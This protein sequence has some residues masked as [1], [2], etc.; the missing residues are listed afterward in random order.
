[1][2]IIPTKVFLYSSI[3]PSVNE[4][5]IKTILFLKFF[6]GKREILLEDLSLNPKELVWSLILLFSNIGYSFSTEPFL[7]KSWWYISFLTPN[8]GLG[9]LWI[10]DVYNKKILV[11]T[12]SK[13]DTEIT[14]TKK[15]VFFWVPFKLRISRTDKSGIASHYLSL[16]NLDLNVCM[17]FY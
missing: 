6:E 12:T 14:I 1:M 4:S 16:W 15:I 5:P 9:S 2:S 17:F 13:I 8:V 11:R 3:R 7:I 10:I